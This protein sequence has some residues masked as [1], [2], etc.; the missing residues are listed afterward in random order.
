LTKDCC[1][2][3]QVKKDQ[4]SLFTFAGKQG[5]NF[6]EFPEQI[7][8]RWKLCLIEN[9]KP[10]LIVRAMYLVIVDRYLSTDSRHHNFQFFWREK[11]N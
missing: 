9:D 2:F 10:I 11:K 1:S 4:T 5:K 7:S 3:I 6:A 8:T